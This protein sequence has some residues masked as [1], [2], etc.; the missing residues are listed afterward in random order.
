MKRSHKDWYENLLKQQQIQV[1][2]GRVVGNFQFDHRRSRDGF[3]K[4]VVKRRLL[5]GF[6][7]NQHYNTYM[8]GYYQPAFKKIPRSTLKSDVI[9]LYKKTKECFIAIFDSCNW[10]FALIC[11]SCTAITNKSYLCITCH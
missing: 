3:A 2:G 5:F 8:H 10:K 7:E 6:D 1:M 9:K 11:D 4:M